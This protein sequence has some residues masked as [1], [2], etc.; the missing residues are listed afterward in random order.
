MVVVGASLAGLRAIQGLREEGFAGRLV[1]VGEEHHLPY[2]RPPLSK[3]VLSGQ[4]APER[5]ALIDEE[6]LDGLGVEAC[7]GHRAVA[8][9][10]DA[11]RIEI[12]DGTSIEAD[13][14]LLAT[15]ARP[16]ELPASTGLAGVTVL[17]TLEDAAAIRAVLD[18]KGQSAHVVVV[19]AGFIGSEVAAT[20]AGLGCRVTVVEALDVPLAGALGRPVGAACGALHVRHG[21]DLRTGVSVQALEAPRSAGTGAVADTS[22]TVALSDGTK[23]EADV[24][25]VGIGVSPCSEWLATSGLVV[26]GGVVCD[27]ALYAADRV[28]AAG[29]VARWAWRRFGR[30]ELVRIEHW[31]LASQMGSTAARSLVA[32]RREA[33]AFTPVPYFWSDQ[34]GLRIQ[35][36]GRPGPDDQIE[37]VDGRLD[38]DDGKFVV[39]YGYDGRLTAALAVSRPRQLMAFRPLL[40]AEAGWDEALALLAT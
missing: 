27:A 6:R 30:E 35:M 12:D 33:P 28:A 36:L 10:A 7:L 32:G 39:L 40:A 1:L 14:V 17:R 21:V 34:Y 19:G 24:V 22:T 9:D 23:L 4:W 18:Q 37:V 25:V 38:A 15:G 8:L 13:A 11:A 16:R 5:T 20:C 31:E 3:Q 29:D 26:D 2:D